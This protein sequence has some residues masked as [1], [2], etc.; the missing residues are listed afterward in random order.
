MNK[1]FLTLAF[2]ATFNLFSQTKYNSDSFRVTQA[3]IETN[4]FEKDSTANAI[5][6]YE[7]GKSWIRNSDYDLVTEEKH[8]LKILTKEGA[9][10]ATVIIYLYHDDSSNYERVKNIVATTYNL[11]DG[12]VIK[13]QLDEKDIF[14]EKHNENYNIV[15][16]TLPNIQEGSVITYSYN[17]ESPFRF[18]YK[19]WHFQHEIPTLS[20]RYQTS[21]P[22]LWEYNIK[23]VGGKKL[24]TNTADV[25]E[26]CLDGPNGS[27]AS[28]LE[29][30]YEMKNIPAFVEEEHMTTRENYLA[31]IEYELKTFTDF[32]GVV[33]DYSKEWKDVDKELKTEPNIGKQLTKSVKLEDLLNTDLINTP[34]GLEKAQEIYNYIQDSYT[35]NGK[36][37]IFKDVSVKDLIKSK[38]GNV[39]SINILLHNILKESGFDVK[40]LLISTR[41][42]GI[43]TTIYPVILDFNYLVVHASIDGKTYLLD[44][45]DKYLSFGELPFKCFNHFGRLL[46]FEKESQWFDIVPKKSD[47]YYSANL[48]IDNNQNIVG[49]IK[50]KITGK[51][52]YDYR[53]SYFKNKTAYVEKLENDFNDLEI[54]DFKTTESSKT[55]PVFKEEYNIKYTPEDTGE[56]LYL[57]PFF[58]KFFTENPFKLQER[59]YPIDFGYKDAFNYTLMLDLGDDY[60]LVDQPKPV[61][62]NLPNKSGKLFFSPTLIGNNL[63]LSL[64]IEFKN[65]IYPPAY[66]P[67]LK[68]FM[69]KIVDI[70]TNT[71]LLLKK[72]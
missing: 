47:V 1:I 50:S 66:Y 58:I 20:S 57:D 12:K 65:A 54:S 37:L 15:K 25:K 49:T 26:D 59:T 51:H 5:I 62:L 21:I 29:S 4:T 27:S 43:P 52:A 28:C 35:W 60:E 6:I 24:T 55:S 16:F 48:K 8:K 23:L 44:A 69:N 33:K 72:K 71:L 34:K 39:S 22:G 19:P 45:T 31:R 18:K 32:Y 36:H 68:A 2:L 53:K 42:H 11:K 40:P 67:Y 61:I 7:A 70:Q 14:E 56:N 3:D 38:T 63:N 41:Q 10:H 17:I 30:V 13:N 46:D 9:K 64:R